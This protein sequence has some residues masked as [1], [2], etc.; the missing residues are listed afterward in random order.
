MPTREEW[1]EEQEVK[2]GAPKYRPSRSGEAQILQGK[3]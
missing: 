1:L 2:K 3:K